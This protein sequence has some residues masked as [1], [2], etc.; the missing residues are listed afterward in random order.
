MA[1]PDISALCEYLIESDVRVATRWVCRQIDR[2]AAK[3]VNSDD[4]RSA[5]TIIE[6]HS[7]N[8]KQI[9]PHAATYS[10]D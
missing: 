1:T 7:Q 3:A 9:L 2:I 4:A 10:M 6:R 5:L 8:S